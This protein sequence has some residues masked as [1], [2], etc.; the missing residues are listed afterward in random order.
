MLRLV[1]VFPAELEFA[2]IKTTNGPNNG[3]SH[4]IA[5]EM[6]ILN[7]SILFNAVTV[8]THA[9]KMRAAYTTNPIM[10]VPLAGDGGLPS[11]LPCGTAGE[12]AATDRSR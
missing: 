3:I 11:P 8:E 10:V 2:A 7:P 5:I 4:D 1:R 9:R 6:T 12:N